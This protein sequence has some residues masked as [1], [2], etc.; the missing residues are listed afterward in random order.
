MNDSALLLL[1][2]R[3]GAHGSIHCSSVSHGAGDLPCVIAHGERGVLDL[4]VSMT[5]GAALRG[6]KEGG[7]GI[8]RIDVP[9]EYF[10]GVSQDGPYIQQLIAILKTGSL[11]DRHFI[12]SILTGT[13]AVPS[14]SDGLAVQRVIDAAARSHTEGRW[15]EL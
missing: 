6:A 15:V 12:D 13:D 1:D 8:D 2:F 4:S 5:E 10:N 9:A 11:G 7:N 3:S 14:F